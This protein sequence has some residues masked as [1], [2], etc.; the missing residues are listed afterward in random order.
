[1]IID[2]PQEML[3]WCLTNWHKILVVIIAIIQLWKFFINYIRPITHKEEEAI[4]K[5]PKEGVQITIKPLE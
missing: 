5:I 2:E 1:M 3:A 4:I